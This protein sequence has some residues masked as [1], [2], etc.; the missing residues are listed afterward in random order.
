[1]LHITYMRRCFE[2]AQLAKGYTAPNPMVGAVLVHED[3][4]IGEG[5]HQYYGADHAEVD[6][7]KNVA[8]PDRYLI[9]Q[10][11]MYVNLEP[12]AHFGLT[13]PCA[14]RLVQERIKRV[15]IANTDPF[16]KVKGNGIGILLEGGVEVT[17]GMLE[18]EGAWLNRRFFCFHTKKRPYIILKWA[19]TSDRFM[20]PV[21]RTRHQITGPE[22]QQLVHKWRTEEGAIMVGTTTAINDNPRLTARL[23]EGRQPLRIALDRNLQLPNTHH[24]L[25]DAAPTWLINELEDNVSGNVRSIKL[26]FNDSLLP[27]ILDQLWQAKIL[28]VIIE[29]GAALL[30]SFISEGL[31]DEARIFT[32]PAALQN[33][34]AT[35][36]LTGGAL[37]FS[38]LIGADQLNIFVNKKSAYPYVSGMEL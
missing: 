21:Q 22:S 12:C 5:Y 13:P 26:P 18:K 29:G 14:T 20:A 3:T 8:E 4:I 10:S 6:C 28:S 24:L 15:S 37:A 38:D 31:W 7:L 27:G 9:P 33:G 35:P 11:A 16:E 23:C 25:D 32:G 19:Q 2:L 30:H 34:I 17:T 36:A 1:M